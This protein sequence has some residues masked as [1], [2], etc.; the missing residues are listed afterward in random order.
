MMPDTENGLFSRFLYYAFEDNS[1]FKNPFVSHRQL[2]YTDFFIEKGRIIFELYEQLNRLQQPVN[3]QLSEEQG[4]R[5]TS[6][7]NSM[8][9]RNKL[10]LGNDFDANIKRLGLISFR[11]A[12]ILSTLRILEDGELA[13]SITCSDIDFETAIAMATTLEK[14]AIAVFRN[15]PNHELK[16]IK[17]KFYE[18]LPDQFDRQ[19]YLAVATDLGINP[20]TA[21]KYIAQFK[22]K[23]LNHEHN[24]YSKILSLNPHSEI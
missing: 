21:E 5:F 15:L 19:G 22:P 18:T 24:Q 10:L 17:L 16:G 13:N 20:K 8:L 3:F 4:Q 6:S 9:S 11:I 7:F 2:N 23:L 14:H 1:E 12:M